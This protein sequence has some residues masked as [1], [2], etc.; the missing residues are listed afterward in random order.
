LDICL[1]TIEEV[2]DGEWGVIL[3]AFLQ[4]VPHPNQ[5]IEVGLIYVQLK[6]QA[7][8]VE[9]VLLGCMQLGVDYVAY[10]GS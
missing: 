10:V 9:T 6:L 1:D 5:V 3:P 2:S 4:T 7:D 8:G